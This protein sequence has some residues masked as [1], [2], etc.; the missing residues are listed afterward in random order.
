M[1]MIPHGSSFSEAARFRLKDFV[2]ETPRESLQFDVAEIEFAGIETLLFRRG[3]PWLVGWV[4]L[5]CC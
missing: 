5:L 4:L 1:T 2:K 3:A